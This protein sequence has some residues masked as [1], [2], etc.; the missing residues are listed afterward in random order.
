MLYTENYHKQNETKEKQKFLGEG[1]YGCVIKPGYDCKGNTNNI[2]NSVT[3]ITEIN[4]ASK[5][6][7]FIGNI[8]KKINHN[9]KKIYKYHFAPIFKYCIMEF[10][11]INKM[12]INKCE[13]FLDNINYPFYELYSNFIKTKFYIFYIRYIYGAKTIKKY[14]DYYNKDINKYNSNYI[15]SFH[16]L[17]NS[18]LLLQ[19]NNIVHNDLYDRNII[20]DNKIN[21]PIIIDFGLSYYIPKLYNITDKKIYLKYINKFYFDFRSDSYYH[22]TDKRF[23]TFFLNNKNDYFVNNV[24]KKTQKNNLTKKLID[25][26]L[27]DANDSILNSKINDIFENDEFLFYKKKNKEFYSKFINK[28][29]YPTYF[30]ILHEMLPNIFEY[31]DIYSLSIEYIK[32]YVQNIT[33]NDKNKIIYNLFIQLYKKTIISD[34]NYKINTLQIKNIIEFFISRINSFNIQNYEVSYQN[35]VNDFDK[36]LLENNIN[37]EYFFNTEYANIDFQKI[38]TTEN[39]RIFKSYNINYKTF[40]YI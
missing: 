12:D 37:K 14:L 11:K 7:L 24:T 36:L 6:E 13:N 10:N 39:I 8:I 9:K 35:F 23:V 1:S 17:L 2:K 27:K 30:S 29:K 38:L 21:S 40:V 19:K 5:N 32:L 18:I 4:F 20:F 28:N 16:Y 22:N 34:K 26:F 3:K 33:Y 31:N 15:Y 25:I